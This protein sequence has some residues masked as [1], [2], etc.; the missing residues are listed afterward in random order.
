MEPPTPEILLEEGRSA[1]SRYRLEEA[2]GLF[3]QALGQSA[4]SDDRPLRARLLEELAYV[5]RSLRDPD[6]A[7]EHYLQSSEIYRS[8]DNPL[9]TAHTMRH[10][11]DILREQKRTDQAAL[12]YSEAI[13]I[14]RSHEATPPLDLGNAIRGF[15]LLKEDAGER[16]QALSLWRE[17]GD[18][19]KLVGIE[20]GI[21]ESAAQIQL[22]S[23]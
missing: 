3:Q 1:K 14:Y 7:R 17:A 18:L 13:A 22:L 10:A 16:A 21:T 15:A 5:E 9:K 12:L 23:E 6:A 2:R 8:L 20:A 11:A 19:Y 4:Q